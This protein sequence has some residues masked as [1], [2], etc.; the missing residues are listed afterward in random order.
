M[1]TDYN[2]Q[3]NNRYALTYC[4]HTFILIIRL[5][6]LASENDTIWVAANIVYDNVMFNVMKAIR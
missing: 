4:W 1:L 5:I 6:F 3:L 2:C